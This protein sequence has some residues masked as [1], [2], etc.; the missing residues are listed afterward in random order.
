MIPVAGPEEDDWDYITDD[1]DQDVARHASGA[2]MNAGKLYVYYS[3]AFPRFETEFRRFEQQNP[4]L[5]QSFQAR[6][7]LWLAVHSLLMY[8][9]EETVSSKAAD[10]ATL[11][12][13]KRQERCRLAT[14]AAMVASQEVK[15]GIAT[16]D[17]EAA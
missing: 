7:E 13:S 2:V 9:E 5:A 3:T 11:I 10:E 12:E 17:M 1:E 14:V 6:Y 4:A 15:T 8:Q 16:E